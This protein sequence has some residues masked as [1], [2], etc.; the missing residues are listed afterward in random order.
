MIDLTP[1]VTPVPPNKMMKKY[2]NYAFLTLTSY[3]W[4]PVEW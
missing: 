2:I 4:N 1:P 3:S